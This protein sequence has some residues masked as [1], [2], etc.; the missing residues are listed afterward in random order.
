SAMPP[1]LQGL[2]RINP[3]TYM[4]DAIR[5]LMIE[6]AVS[7]DGLGLD[8]AVLL[9]GLGLLVALAARLYPRLA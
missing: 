5:S 1:W 4:V 8:L 9:V 6:G 3:L 2:A 7:V